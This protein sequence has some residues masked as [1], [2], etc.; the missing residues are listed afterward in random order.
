MPHALISGRSGE[1]RPRCR[2]HVRPG[3]PRTDAPDRR[4][5]D[6]IAPGEVSVALGVG[7]DLGNL[8]DRE[9]SAA[10]RHRLDRDVAVARPAAHVAD[11]PDAAAEPLGQ[12]G[13]AG[14]GL[15]CASY[16]V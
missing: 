16:P 11:R 5:V 15:R 1:R 6:A 10:L 8:R 3:A 13:S 2:G 4:L 14:L 12:G 9:P 7:L